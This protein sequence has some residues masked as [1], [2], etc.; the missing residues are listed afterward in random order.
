MKPITVFEHETLLINDVGKENF[1]EHQLEALQ[2]YYGNKG[3]P[4]FSLIHKGVRFND[5]VGVIQVGDSVIEVLDNVDEND[6]DEYD[7]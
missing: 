5:Y 2:R 3:V 1:S 7:D 6:E 4:Y